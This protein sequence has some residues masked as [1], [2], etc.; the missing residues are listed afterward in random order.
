MKVATGLA[1]GRRA[2]P[3]LAA[4]AVETAMARAE[5]SI[6][7][8]VLLY[9]SADFAGEPR[10]AITA[11]AR[12]ANCTQVAGCTAAGVFTE[13]DWVLDAP[14]AAALVLGEGA[15]LR[16]ARA[17]DAEVLTLAA[18]NAVDMLWFAAGGARYG[19]IAGD[20]SGQG[21]YSVWAGGRVHDDGRAELALTGAS[22]RLGV[23]QG[24]RPLSAPAVIERVDGHDVQMLGGI[25]ALPSL[26]R[27]LPMSARAPAR[28]PTH[29]LM[30]GIPYGEAESALA[31]GRYHLL[32][33]VAANADDQSV[34][35]AGQLQPGMRL[36]WALRQPRAAEQDMEAAVAQLA[37]A[38]LQA[39]RFALMFPCMERGPFFYGGQDRDIHVLARRFP[40]MPLIGFYGNGEIAHMDG[41]NRLLQYSVVLALAYEEA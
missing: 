17:D 29:L 22:L 24:V 18:P 6:A 13:E 7:G 2:E 20:A 26:A 15:S 12:A 34:T 11:A 23:S 1:V 14:A 5:L 33:V 39:P 38:S 16:P 8:T 30:A 4:R 35:V 25:A 37:D 32:P 27:E 41:A 3:E 31:E 40:E 10:A 19:G 36:F 28:I 9:L 21:P